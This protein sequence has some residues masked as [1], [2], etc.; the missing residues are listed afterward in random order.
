MLKRN[1]I[2][3][4]LSILASGL[5][6]QDAYDTSILLHEVNIN[7]YRYTHFSAGNKIQEIDSLS[8]SNQTS[9][10]LAEAISNLTTLYLKSYGISGNSSIS[11]RGT[12][13]SH[14]AVLW[15][16]INLQDPLNGGSNLE[17]IPLLAVNTV[18][19]Q[20]GGSGALFGSGAIG[21]AIIL[22]SKLPLR[23]GFHSNVSL[24]TGSFGRYFGNV[25]VQNSGEK[26]ATSLRIFYQKANNDFP[27]I[28]TQQFG[29]PETRQTNASAEYYGMSQDNRLLF[30]KNQ[31]LNTHF[32]YQKSNRELP[33]NMT[34]L[35]SKQ[36]QRDA[37]FRFS[38]DYSLSKSRV[39][40]LTRFGLLYSKLNY[41][42]SLSAIYAEHQSQSALLETE[43]NYKMHKNHL[44]NFGMHERIDW[45]ISANYSQTKSR[46]NLAF[47]V[48]YQF[49]TPS[50]KFQLAAS[51]RQEM[52]DIQWS[53]PTPSVSWKF[54]FKRHF[55]IEGKASLNY[56][57]PS[58]NDLFWQDGFAHGNPDLLPESAWAEDLS[59]SYLNET[60]PQLF[61]FRLTA[62]NSYIKNLILWMPIDGIWM[63]VNQKEVWSRGIETDVDY[64]IKLKSMQISFNLKGSYNPSTLEKNAENESDLSLKKQL[65][66]TPKQQLRAQFSLI[67]AYGSLQLEH[68]FVSE[69]YTK[70]DNSASLDAYQLT[71]LSLSAPILKQK[72]T[73]SFRLQNLFNTIYQSM[74]NYALPGRNY[75]LNIHYNFN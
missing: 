11:L 3:L 47:L 13:S 16:G 67:H 26:L 71:N 18:K 43:L 49:L 74:E 56:R 73:L 39:D 4:L 37:F 69:R 40:W 62:F 46:N 34:I 68:A 20:Y 64:K 75:Q 42:D 50:K 55:Q 28:N 70:T 35:Q 48:S 22:E 44:F 23:S 32:W 24:G 36:Q 25:S 9:N 38:M 53:Q 6:A 45:G 54:S 2:S 63:P 10:S 1:L 57:Q 66:Y 21:G 58:F 17:L 41:T 12:S 29:H 5:L 27:F 65:I 33:P 61:K 19:I 14:T 52:I 72:L 60:Y 51:I 15:N 59:F 30:S 8:L 31:Q 7:S